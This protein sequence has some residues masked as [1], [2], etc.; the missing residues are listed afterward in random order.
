MG[1]LNVTGHSDICAYGVVLMWR[2]SWPN[3]PGY[4]KAINEYKIYGEQ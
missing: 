1:N 4:F 3:V 2:S